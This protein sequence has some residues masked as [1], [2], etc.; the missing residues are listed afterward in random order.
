MIGLF[1]GHRIVVSSDSQIFLTLLGWTS[2]I[3]LSFRWGL[4]LSTLCSNRL[5][6]IRPQSDFT[7]RTNLLIS[8]NLARLSIWPLLPHQP[9]WSL[10]SIGFSSW[11]VMYPV[12]LSSRWVDSNNLTLIWD[13]NSSSSLS[14]IFYLG[15][16][17]I[18]NPPSIKINLSHS[19]FP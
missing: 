9:T 19:H 16:S 7:H 17:S 14:L 5:F 10:L 11:C 3:K 6:L 1:L 18:S 13:F 15:S 12:N 4:I 8:F 2:A